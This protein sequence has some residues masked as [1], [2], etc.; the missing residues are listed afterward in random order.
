MI[1]VISKL[2]VGYTYLLIPIGFWLRNFMYYV[3]ILFMS[4]SQYDQMHS[5]NYTLKCVH[6]RQ[7][8]AF[9][10]LWSNIYNIYIYTYD[11]IWL[12]MIASY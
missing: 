2:T 7:R 9:D 1:A 5:P 8:I 11:Y 4:L 12:I 3:I 10:W 6:T